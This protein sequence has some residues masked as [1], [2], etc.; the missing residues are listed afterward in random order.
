MC[1]YFMLI[2]LNKAVVVFF[3][4]TKR[5][6]SAKSGVWEILHNT[7]LDFFNKNWGT[8]SSKGQK[9]QQSGIMD[10]PYL[11]LNSSKKNI[12]TKTGEMGV[13]TENLTTLRKYYFF[14]SGNVCLCFCL[15]FY[16]LKEFSSFRNTYRNTDEM[17]DH[18]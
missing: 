5:M 14:S 2:T 1:S 17:T 4:Y 9:K 13:Q 10:R 15:C 3:N 8:Y 11:K 16:I 12:L 6:R 7:R 18:V